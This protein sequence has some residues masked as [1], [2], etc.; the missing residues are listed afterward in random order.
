MSSSKRPRSSTPS[1]SP[2]VSDDDEDSVSKSLRLT[3]PASSRSSATNALTCTLPPSCHPPHN[4]PTHLS[5]AKELEAHYAKYHA[6]VCEEKRCAKVFPD[7]RLLELHQTECHDPI[8]AVRK[9]RGEKIFSCFLATCPKVFSSPKNR[10]LHLIQAHGYPK[11]FFFAVTNKGIGG[12]LKKWG[13]GASL[14][15]GTWHAREPGEK[16][17]EDER[18]EE[19]KDEDEKDFSKGHLDAKENE[20]VDLPSEV[21]P[22]EGGPESNDP[23]S[24]AS[25]MSSLS[26]VPP[27]IRFGRGGS[28]QGFLSSQRG[29]GLP[30][31]NKA[32]SR[33]LDRRAEDV[34]IQKTTVT[35]RSRDG[36]KNLADIPTLPSNANVDGKQ[37][38]VDRTT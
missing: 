3:S 33:C 35:K 10:R 7:E 38:N 37:D 31:E 17:D 6:H 34:D 2:S 1:S 24:L 15:R 27:S 26:L 16:M 22:S 14:I 11:E 5:N 4:A 30:K 13:E 25:A 29:R 19:E 9:E 36:R 23:D 8:A 21:V 28:R 12:L 32:D 20:Q 18:S